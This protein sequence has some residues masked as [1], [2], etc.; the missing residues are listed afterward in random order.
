MWSD[1]TWLVSND[2]AGLVFNLFGATLFCLV[3]KSLPLFSESL[4]S[5]FCLRLMLVHCYV[6]IDD[7]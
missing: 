3:M 4:K 6:P 2:F 5:F 1:N 7:V